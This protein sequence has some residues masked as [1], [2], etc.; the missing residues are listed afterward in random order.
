MHLT[1]TVAHLNVCEGKKEVIK[2]GEN[3][4]SNSN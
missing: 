4:T 3:K 2:K 1:V